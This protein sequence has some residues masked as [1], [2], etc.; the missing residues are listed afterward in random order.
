ME[1]H[2]IWA[3]AS[4]VA[5]DEDP[6]FIRWEV[7]PQE[8]E[9]IKVL[10]DLVNEH[11]LV[12]IHVSGSP[13]QW[14]VKNAEG[15]DFAA[16]QRVRSQEMRVGKDFVLFYAHGKY[17]DVVIESKPIQTSTLLECAEGEPRHHF[18]GDAPF[19]GYGVRETIEGIHA[20]HEIKFEVAKDAS[21]EPPQ[22]IMVRT[23][24]SP[25]E[26]IEWDIHPGLSDR[27][28]NLIEESDPELVR[29]L[30]AQ[31]EL[32]ET[33][34][35]EWIDEITFIAHKDGKFGLLAE[36]ELCS[37]ESESRF[38]D[39]TNWKPRKTLEEELIKNLAIFKAKFPKCEFASPDPSNIVQ[40]RNALWAFFEVGTMTTD[41]RKELE[42]AIFDYGYPGAKTEVTA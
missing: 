2:V 29:Q 22:K 11:D 32:L 15:D 41:E 27:W 7:T 9:R 35:S 36:L 37:I 39:D 30:Q 23:P 34:R 28:G 31:P 14:G 1:H 4:N 20:E 8:I 38:E 19:F 21:N 24:E 16:L 10:S 18:L 26:D 17:E 42:T 6:G 40:E 33:L 25:D 13:G 5:G 3:L 12:E